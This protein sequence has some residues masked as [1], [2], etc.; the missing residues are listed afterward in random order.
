VTLPPSAQDDVL[1]EVADVQAILKC[2]LSYAYEKM[3]HW[4]PGFRV[5]VGRRTL[6]SRNR[7]MEWIAQAGDAATPRTR[8][9][10]GASPI[11]TAS[12]DTPPARELRL[13]FPPRRRRR[14]RDR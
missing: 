1:L 9:K 6:V 3:R 5:K 4:P 13:T 12:E 2:S 11:A 14:G 7:L 8:P 10:R